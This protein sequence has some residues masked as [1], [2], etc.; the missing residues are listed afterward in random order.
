MNRRNPQKKKIEPQEPAKNETTER[1]HMEE[2]QLK[3]KAKL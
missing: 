2:A 3:E 1:K